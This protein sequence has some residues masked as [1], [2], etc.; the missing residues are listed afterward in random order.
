M[1]AIKF[2]G[3]TDFFSLTKGTKQLKD[4]LSCGLERNIATHYLGWILPLRNFG[5]Y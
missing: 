4:P 3:K 2:L 1:L 5:S